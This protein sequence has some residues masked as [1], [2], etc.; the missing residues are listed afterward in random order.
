VRRDAEP[1]STVL[2]SGSSD[3]EIIVWNTKTGEV[4]TKGSGN[5]RITCM[6]SSLECSVQES[7]H[8]KKRKTRK[9]NISEENETKIQKNPADSQVKKSSSSSSSSLKK[10]KGKI[11]LNNKSISKKGKRKKMAKVATRS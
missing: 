10:R 11:H 2:V 8:G 5:G 9:N 6:S 1:A 4:I 7:L 3:G